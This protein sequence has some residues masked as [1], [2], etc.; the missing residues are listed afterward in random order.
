[1]LDETQRKVVGLLNKRRNIF[2]TG[3][4]GTGKT[5]TVRKWM[6]E[7]NRQVV[8]TATTGIAAL[9]LGG[10]TIHRFS[11]IGIKARPELAE[12]TVK[13]WHEKTYHS[14]W[15]L[16]QWRTVEY[17]DTLVIDEVSMLRSDQ[18]TL[19]DH[20][21][22]GVR[23]SD[24]PF[25]GIQM[26]FTGD[27]FQ[28]PPVV[29]SFDAAKYRDLERPFAF[30]SPSWTE[31]EL[32]T[33][34]LEVN[35]RQGDG[36]W[37]DILTRLRRG[38][39]GDVTALEAR[40]GATFAGD[41]KPV[42]LFPLKANVAAENTAALRALPGEPV[43]APA[44]YQGSPGWCDALKKDLPADDPLILKPGAQ[45]MLTTNDLDRRWVNGTMGVVRGISDYGVEVETV[46]GMVHTVSEAEW[47]KVE[48]TAESGRIVETVLATARQYPLKLAWA[49]T[50]HKSQG[51]T[52]DRAELGLS[53]C[54]APGQ[55]YV[56]LS[57]VRSLEGL[58]LRSW[59]PEVVH[60][61]PDVLEFYDAA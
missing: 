60:A 55:A 39:I 17:T 45:V 61:H 27:F 37:L 1:M 51:M 25:G 54:F 56:A 19:I 29:T 12:A 16:K 2:L 4:A 24:R 33:V 7:T 15:S 52:L 10:Q 23:G 57:R 46:D 20:V 8:L 53:G 14:K 26:I 11:G 9:L 18:I 47:K 50:I 6:K 28:L 22:R 34:E 21:L 42:R 40:V 13:A 44:D 5:H 30:Q 58:S 36:V 32:K 41:V 48:Y 49:S 43:A 3:G 38:E 35:H 31:A 59:D